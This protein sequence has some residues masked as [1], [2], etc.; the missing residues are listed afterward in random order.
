M[1]LQ[2]VSLQRAALHEQQDRK[3]DEI[4]QR[5]LLAKQTV[6]LALLVGAFLVFFLIDILNESIAMSF[7]S[8]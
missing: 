4:T 2:D 6:W 1:G 3:R 7:A 5:W 8:F